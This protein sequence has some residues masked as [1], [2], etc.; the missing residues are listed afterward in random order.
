MA[1][2]LIGKYYLYQ[3]TRS[4]GF[5][6]PIFALFVLRDLSF[7]QYG[8]LS[9]L[10]SA[11]V[12][13]GEVPTGYIGDRY[14]QRTSLALSAVFTALSLAGF[15][16]AQSFWPYVLFWILW[17][18][19]LTF[20]SG[21]V[22]AWLYEALERY[23]DADEF[24]RIRGRG[25]SVKQ[26]TSVI[27]MILGGALYALD[28]TYPFVASVILNSLGLLVLFTLPAGRT[29][30]NNSSNESERVT[31]IEALPLIQQRFASQP[32]RPFVIYA[33]LFFAVSSAADS[34][35]QPVARELFQAT[36]ESASVAGQSL[37]LGVV[38][39]FLYAGFTVISAIGSYFADEVKET[40]GLWWTL[41]LVPVATAVLLVLPRIVVIAALPMFVAIRG[42]KALLLPIVNGYLN[43]H[44]GSA[45]RATT[46][47][48]F[49]MSY[50]LLRIPLVLAAGIVADIVSETAAVAVLGGVFLLGAVATWVVGSPAE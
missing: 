19:A 42:S 17:A 29:T 33:G 45:G 21:S 47:S 36:L 1:E 50:Q 22:D 10:Y 38:L 46:L 35:I 5:I 43:D 18:F 14:G 41:L 49:S 32:L 28:P 2:R 44:I 16:V 25:A 31:I 30:G 9:A 34:Y 12:V 24:V 4:I 39:G 7:T 3:A 37:P 8:T 20:A 15:V 6:S 13:L 27:T 11:L 48:A 23:F 40:L 26:W